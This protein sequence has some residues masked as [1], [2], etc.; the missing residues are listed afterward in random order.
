MITIKTKLVGV[1]PLLINRFTEAAA[2]EATKGNRASTV[3]TRPPPRED[4]KA[5]LYF[6]KLNGKNVPVMPTTNILRSI[7][8]G[9]R[10]FKSGKSKITTIRHSII[11]AAMAIETIYVAIE[12]KKP[13]DVDSRAIRNPATGGRFLRY[14]PVFYDWALSFDLLI[15][16]E[17]LSEPLSREIVDAAG[18]RIGLGDFR[19]DCKGP[20][21]RFRVDIWKP[22]K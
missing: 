10:F 1:T 16:E 14:R 15:D 4:A 11:P 9:G 3:G 6:A 8:E 2:E 12:H 18:K 5:R 19:P 13:W 21:G 22:K 20:F 17:L 7:T